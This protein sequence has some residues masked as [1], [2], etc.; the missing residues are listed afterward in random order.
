[1]KI[2]DS[3]SGEKAGSLTVLL[4]PHK[5]LSQLL[6]SRWKEEKEHWTTG[7]TPG[8]QILYCPKIT[9]DPERY[10]MT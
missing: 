10:F 3:H 5:N 6:L 9:K 2:P 4:N 8:G 1:M 7:I